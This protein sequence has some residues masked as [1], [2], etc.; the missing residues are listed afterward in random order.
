MRHLLLLMLAFTMLPAG[1]RTL[2]GIVIPD[3]LNVSGEKQALQLSG[4][5]Y[6]KKFMFKV[7]IGAL[8]TPAPV[9]T[10]EAAMQPHGARV[11]RMHFLRA[12]S[13]DK[14]AQGWIDTFEANHNA[15][16]Q[17]ALV[18]RMNE[19]NSMMPDVKPND[20]MRL[21]LLSG[22]K[23]RVLFNDIQRGT[24]DGADFQQ[25]LLRLWLG[26]KPADATM[27]QALLGGAN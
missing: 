10:V 19:L 8:Y 9:R 13:A 25:A 23:T 2:D 16:E 6:R 12:V 3:T 22:G 7:Y 17:R 27:K 1:A 4:A 14:M 21:E 11:M 15:E 20:V 26:S 18:N 5:G 24:I